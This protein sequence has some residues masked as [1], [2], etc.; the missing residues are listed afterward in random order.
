MSNA[1]F[2]NEENQ[3]I[4]QFLRD[5]Y[6]IFP[7]EDLKNLQQI[8]EDLYQSGIEY[9]KLDK[10]PLIDDFFD[11]I[12]QWINGR[13]L[14]DFRVHLINKL[15]RDIS[16]PPK[17]YQ[18]A[19]SHIH[20]IV[21]N[22]LAIQRSCNLSI[23]I[24]HDSSS[25]LP[26]HSDVWSGNSPYEIVLWFP[27]VNCY[28][29]KS[30]FVLP[31]YETDRITSHFSEYASMNAED[32]FHQIQD[33]LHWLEVPYGHGVIFTHALLHGNR[34]NEEDQTRWALNIRFKAL[35]SP[36]G[37]KE[38]GESFIPVTIRPMTRMGYHYKK[39]TLQ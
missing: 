19:K 39:T 21:G 4:D 36:Y 3:C 16:L 12:H 26:L 6:T 11:N 33:Q 32:L 30:M 24:P 22:E 37:D 23:Q 25:L 20:W 31:K 27:F 5:G 38:L 13:N 14:N 1:F 15:T 17:I 9:L 8:K 2:T 10:P 29:T 28:R 35:L 34:I 7:L 18:L